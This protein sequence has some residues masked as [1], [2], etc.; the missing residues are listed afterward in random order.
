MISELS[1]IEVATPD[2]WHHLNHN[3]PDQRVRTNAEV[4]TRVV[5]KV[6]DVMIYIG[7]PYSN[8]ALHQA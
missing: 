6:Q 7:L 3:F 2:I 5:V 1:N 4:D 8:V